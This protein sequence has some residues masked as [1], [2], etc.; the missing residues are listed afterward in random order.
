M[1]KQKTSCTKWHQAIQSDGYGRK[2]HKGKLHYAHRLAY[3][4]KYGKFDGF[5]DHLCRNRSCVN[6]DH[7]EPVSHA[8]NS[9][10]G[11]SA[12]ITQR[13]ADK[14]RV[15]YAQSGITQSETGRIFG[16]G[17]DQVSRIINNKCW[18]V[19]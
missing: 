16:I 9:R 19:L 14:I 7:L 15:V 2:W 11:A 13:L 6:P 8:E 5:L 18:K 17:Q 4:K 1:M 12:K 10:R 3:E